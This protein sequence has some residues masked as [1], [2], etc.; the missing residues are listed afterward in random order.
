MTNF[1]EDYTD[2]MQSKAW[3]KKRIKRLKKDNFTCQQCGATN[4]PLD[5]HHLTYKRFK[6]ERMSDLKSLCRDCHEKAHGKR[7]YWDYKICRTCGKMLIT[8]IK[9]VKIFGAW[10]TDYTCQD[11]HMRSYRD[12]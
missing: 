2:Y 10:W 6:H 12:E 8:L 7:P 1:T 4:K 9:R 3:D 11:G 5:V